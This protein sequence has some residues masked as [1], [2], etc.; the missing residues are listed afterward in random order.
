MLGFGA[1]L[2]VCKD[3]TAT[4]AVDAA[5]MTLGKVNNRLVKDGEVCNTV[6]IGKLGYFKLCYKY[7]NKKV[8]LSYKVKKPILEK[9]CTKVKIPFTKKKKKVCVPIKPTFAKD[10]GTVEIAD[11]S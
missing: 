10:S 3:G 5:G 4:A 1:K 8:Q 7:K 11:F 6:G 9:K 2:N